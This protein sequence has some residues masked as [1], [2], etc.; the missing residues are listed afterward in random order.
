[1]PIISKYKN[2]DVTTSL[3][4]QLDQTL[5]CIGSIINIAKEHNIYYYSIISNNYFPII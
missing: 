3:T 1:M 5:S 2:F 4:S